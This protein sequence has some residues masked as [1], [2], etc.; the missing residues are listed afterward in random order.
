MEAPVEL[1]LP[2]L[3]KHTGADDEATLQIA[4][5]NQLLDE[6]ARHD[7]LPGAGI[8]GEEEAQRLAGEHRLVDRGDLVREG[9]N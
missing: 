9:L 2:L 1:V 7:R 5:S 8:V 3:G 6:E 4:A